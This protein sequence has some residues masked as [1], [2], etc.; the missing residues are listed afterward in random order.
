MTIFV[1][2]VILVEGKGLAFVSY[3]E[4][5]PIQIRREDHLNDP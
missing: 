4:E 2:S 3:A 5:L 1:F